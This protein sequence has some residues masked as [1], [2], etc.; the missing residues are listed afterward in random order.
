MRYLS[1]SRPCN[2]LLCLHSILLILF[3]FIF[4]PNKANAE[5]I[6]NDSTECVNLLLIFARGSGQNSLK[7]HLRTPF[8]DNF[9]IVEKES[10]HFFNWH[11][12]LLQTKYPSVTYKAVTIHD[13]I[14]KYDPVGY[15]SVGIF[16]ELDNLINAEISFYPG[17]Y[18]YSVGHGVAET[19]GYLKDQI[20]SCPDQSLILG[21]FSQGAQVI[22]DSL[23]QLTEQ[24]RDNILGVGLVGDP[25]YIGASGGGILN[26]F[27]DSSSYSW[28]RGDA[29]AQDSIC[30]QR[31][32]DKGY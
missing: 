18:R 8:E 30:T 3:V 15:K 26:P 32:G 17:E 4:I 27:E 25:K 2:R 22:G 10:Y 14:G 11:K 6:A 28:R 21:G 31:Y 9:R 24:E 16:P 1:S 13:F 5:V 12:E 7:E 20:A 19:V 29:R 23:F